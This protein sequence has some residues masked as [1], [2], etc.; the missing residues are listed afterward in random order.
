L[1]IS[2]SGDR[3]L[4]VHEAGELEFQPEDGDPSL[5]NDPNMQCQN[6]SKPTPLPIDEAGDL[7][8]YSLPQNADGTVAGEEDTSRCYNVCESSGA[9]DEIDL[10]EIAI[11]TVIVESDCDQD[12]PEV[13]SPPPFVEA[14]LSSGEDIDLVEMATQIDCEPTDSSLEPFDDEEHWT[15]ELNAL[16]SA[17]RLDTDLANSCGDAAGAM[18]DVDLTERGIQ[19]V[20]NE[21][22][23][24]AWA[25][26][27]VLEGNVGEAD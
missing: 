3:P 4:H 24:L 27:E 21:E 9:I 11:Q 23:G 18:E 6:P 16:A 26:A 7:F 2:E 17:R 15:V 8:S 10:V 25:I 19:A 13:T 22:L 12:I 14:G 5:S 20:S 1:Q